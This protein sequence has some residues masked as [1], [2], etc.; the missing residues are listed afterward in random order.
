MRKLQLRLAETGSSLS[1]VRS[2]SAEQI[3]NNEQR[4]TNNFYIVVE[5]ILARDEQ[6]PSDFPVSGTTGYDFLDAVNA[7]FVDSDGLKQLDAFYCAFTGVTSS[8]ADIRYEKKKQVIQELFSGEMRSLGKKLSAIAMADRNARDFA[9]VDLTAAL[10]EV[11]ACLSVYRTYVRE[12]EPSPADRRYI[13]DAIA[14]ARSRAGTSLDERLFV[15]LERVL[16]VD[17]PSYL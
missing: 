5:K 4:R 15:F 9:P 2:S 17:P 10:A 8:F 16:L 3:T 14:C 11:T 1:V 6:L 13:Q 12:G 7:V